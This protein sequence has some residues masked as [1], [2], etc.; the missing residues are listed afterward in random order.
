MIENSKH[1]GGVNESNITAGGRVTAKVTEN[2]SL[3]TEGFINNVT[4]QWGTKEQNGGQYKLAA[5]P[6]IQLEAGE[7]ARPV[8]RATAA[9]IGGDKKITGLN[10]DVDLRYGCQYEVWF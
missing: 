10:K 1:A 4:N 8:I 6:T 3:I 9:I 2:L 5:G 7:W